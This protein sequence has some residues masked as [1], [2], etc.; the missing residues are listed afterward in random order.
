MSGS[1]TGNIIVPNGASCTLTNASVRGNV[2]VLQNASLTIDATAQPTTIGGNVEAVNCASALLKGGVTVTGSVQ[3]VQCTQMSGFM[4]PGVRIGG[5][6]QCVNNAGGCEADLGDVQGNV[7]IVGS[8][9][10]S[11]ISLVAVG[12]NL[13][14]TGNTPSPTHSFGPDF[15]NGG[16]Q[17]Q[18]AANLGFAPT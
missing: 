9:A 15:V 8:R 11:D 17:A 18:C 3:I 12:G 4:G 7:Q 10:A 14:C 5:N 13:Q 2:Q 1:I 6:F 16:L